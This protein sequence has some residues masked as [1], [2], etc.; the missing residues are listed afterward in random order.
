MLK[1]QEARLTIKRIQNL[2]FLIRNPDMKLAKPIKGHQ[3]L[4]KMNY[5]SKKNYNE[6]KKE[7][8]KKKLL[9]YLKGKI[10]IKLKDVLSLKMLHQ[11]KQ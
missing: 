1:V 4:V 7:N 10:F 3:I 5:M 6:L 11:N 9:F 8:L 2:L